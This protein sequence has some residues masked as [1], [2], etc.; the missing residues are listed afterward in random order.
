MKLLI[1]NWRKFSEQINEEG[2]INQLFNEQ[3]QVFFENNPH[4]VKESIMDI[5]NSMPTSLK[6]VIVG[7][8]IL[9]SF[10]GNV[11]A[12]APPPPPQEVAAQVVDAAKEMGVGERLQHDI[13]NSADT[14]DRFFAELFGQTR[15]GAETTIAIEKGLEAESPQAAQKSLQDYGVSR[16]LVQSDGNELNAKTEHGKA[17]LVYTDVLKDVLGNKYPSAEEIQRTEDAFQGS[18]SSEQAELIT[19]R[20]AYKDVSG[21]R[22]EFHGPI[23]ISIIKLAPSLAA[24]SR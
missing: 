9:T 7:A 6:K 4:L 17:T 22:F 10:M 13:E 18:V 21:E 23:Q 11:A 2:K 14:V 16:L 20:K 24:P 12:A 8:G 3:L 15:A 19:A 5:A 1:E